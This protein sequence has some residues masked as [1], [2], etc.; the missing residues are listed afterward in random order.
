MYQALVGND[1]QGFCYYERRRDYG[2]PELDLAIWMVGLG[3]IARQVK[4]ALYGLNDGE[5]RPRAE[6]GVRA[7]ETPPLDEAWLA[8]P[9]TS[10]TTSRNARARPTA[11]SSSRSRRFPTWNPAEAIDLLAECRGCC[12]CWGTANFS[13]GPEG[14]SRGNGAPDVS[15]VV[16]RLSEAKNF[17]LSG[18]RIGR[19]RDPPI[20]RLSSSGR[21]RTSANPWAPNSCVAQGCAQSTGEPNHHGRLECPKRGPNGAAASRR[22]SADPSTTTFENIQTQKRGKRE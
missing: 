12:G 22:Q 7:I 18:S 16:C 15:P 1:R 13:A 10:A 6:D 4:D 17:G 20:R 19:S 14:L 21:R 8:P 9:R 5:W 2:R 11:L 3:C